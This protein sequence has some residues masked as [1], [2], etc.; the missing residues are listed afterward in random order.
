MFISGDAARMAMAMAM[1]MKTKM[2]MK[3][4]LT[5]SRPTTERTM[6]VFMEHYY[7]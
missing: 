6:T 7:L 4:I 2:E 3:I 5:K 1:T